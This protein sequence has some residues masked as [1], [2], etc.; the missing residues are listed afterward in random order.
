MISKSISVSEQTNNLSDFAAL[1]F[2]WMIP[3]ADDY[4]VIK[5]SAKVIK[6]LV[7]PMRQHTA[8]QVDAALNEMVEQDLIWRYEYEGTE[9]VQFKTWDKH[10]EGLHK[11][12]EPKLPTHDMV[13]NDA[14]GKFREVPG[15]S[16]NHS[17][18]PGNSRLT[19]LNRTEQNR[20]EREQ[21]APG[22]SGSDTR[23]KTKFAEFVSLTNDEYSSL[24]AELGESGAKRCIEILDNYKGANG[25]KYR[26]DYRAIKNWV[27]DRYRDEIRK[28]NFPG[29]GIT[30]QR[31]G[32]DSRLAM[33]ESVIRGF[34]ASG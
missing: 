31:A 28:A 7:I 2:T 10:Q 9:Y 5:G 4:G 3:H 25:R 17:E 12:T 15:N 32:P 11:R 30:G 34:D 29:T 6:A 19:E 14:S 22:K 1:L 16:G 21:K 8:A 24:V 20:R 33:V 13:A 26:S 27:I 18:E 23:P